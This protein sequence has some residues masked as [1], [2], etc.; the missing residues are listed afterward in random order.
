VGE[1]N[2]GMEGD[3]KNQKRENLERKW[4]HREEGKTKNKG[5][6]TT[7]R[8]KISIKRG[9]H[10]VRIGPERTWRIGGRWRLVG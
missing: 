9:N 4:G 7:D 1:D 3:G 10:T 5:S 6:Y 2:D 8:G